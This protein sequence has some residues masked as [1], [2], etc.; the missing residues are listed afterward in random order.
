VASGPVR[1]ASVSTGTLRETKGNPK[2]AL[3]KKKAKRSSPSLQQKIIEEEWE[4]MLSRPNSI[5]DFANYPHHLNWKLNAINKMMETTG[6]VGGKMQE[7]CDRIEARLKKLKEE[8][9]GVIEILS[10]SE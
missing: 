7:N 6:Q 1:V 4:K 8:V 3:P 9:I 10:D 2:N 5:Q